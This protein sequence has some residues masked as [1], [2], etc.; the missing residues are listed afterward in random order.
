DT[1]ISK[2]SL[3]RNN[4]KGPVKKNDIYRV[5]ESGGY[6]DLELM[7]REISNG[8]FNRSFQ[9]QVHIKEDK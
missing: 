4:K 7:L 9:A 5:Y 1:I 3:E 6:F 2:A 8:P